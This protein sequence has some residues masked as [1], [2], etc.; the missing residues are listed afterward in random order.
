[1]I[2]EEFDELDEP[3]KALAE[4]F[5]N[6]RNFIYMGRE[7]EYPAALEG[8]LKL[9]EISYILAE[10]S[11]AAEMKHGPIA[12]IDKDMHVLA[13]AVPDP[14][15]EKMASNVQEVKARGGVV[16]SIVG[17]EDTV[18]SGMSDHFIRIP[19][20]DPCLM[21]I[22]VAVPLQLFAYYI[23]VAKGLDVDQPRNLAKSV[24]VE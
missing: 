8:A 14:I 24:T 7:Y 10:G 4:K 18:V 1:M 12:L 23:A 2:Q 16:I 22:L 3:L 21:P 9:K 5:K 6:T 15:Y 13:I 11:P 20:V 19:T 17:K